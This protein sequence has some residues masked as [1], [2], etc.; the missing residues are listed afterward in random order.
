MS[1]S[2]ILKEYFVIDKDSQPIKVN[3]C[4]NGIGIYKYNDIKNCK[5]DGN[6]TCEHVN[7]HQ[8][9]IEKN[10]AHLY[11]YPKLIV[12]PHKILGKPMDFYKIE[13]LVKN[14]F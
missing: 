4:F 3:S 8:E 9:M 10:K 11:I 1:K 14:N 2:D 13:K 7:F 5:Y 12:G 6:N